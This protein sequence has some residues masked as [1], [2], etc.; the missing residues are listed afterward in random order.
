METKRLDITLIKTYI[1]FYLAYFL[2]AVCNAQTGSIQIMLSNSE[3]GSPVPFAVVQLEG[4]RPPHLTNEMGIV[5]FENLPYGNYTLLIKHISYSPDTII[6]KLEESTIFKRWS[7]QPATNQLS[8]V[9]LTDS[10]QGVQV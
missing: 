8:S 1:V 7:L 4:I 6:I 10:T 5:E 2:G 9:E 3:T